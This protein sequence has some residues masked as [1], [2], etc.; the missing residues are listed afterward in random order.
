VRFVGENAHFIASGAGPAA[1]RQLY[2][3]CYSQILAYIVRR[4]GSQDAADLAAEVFAVA[5]RRI[6]DVP[7]GEGALPWLYGVA[8]RVVS[9]HRRTKGRRVR[10][11]QRLGGLAEAS[12]PNPETTVVQRREYELVLRAASR[13]RPNDQ[14]VLRL[15]L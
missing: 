11:I 3:T 13:L 7:P 1:Y 10:L 4:V 2:E 5:W 12:T 8:Y 6:D 9:H 14:E 15:A